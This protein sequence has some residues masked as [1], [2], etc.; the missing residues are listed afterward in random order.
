MVGYNNIVNGSVH[1]RKTLETPFDGLDKAGI[2]FEEVALETLCLSDSLQAKAHKAKICVNI[3]KDVALGL[4][5][6]RDSKEFVI[7][8]TFYDN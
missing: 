5:A 6:S 3:K 2:G 7:I 8:V 1:L 4:Q